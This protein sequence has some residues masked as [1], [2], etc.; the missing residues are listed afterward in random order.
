MF[1]KEIL[2]LFLAVICA[3]TAAQQNPTLTL[4]E[5]LQ[6]IDSPAQGTTQ[7]AVQGTT[8]AT[9]STTSAPGLFGAP[10]TCP[11]G[12]RKSYGKCIRQ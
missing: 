1:I 9:T 11:E 4:E 2:V 3:F 8:T 5:I 6:I 10:R 12:F 7:R